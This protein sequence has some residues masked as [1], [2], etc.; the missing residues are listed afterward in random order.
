ME[1]VS[2]VAVGVTG[3]QGEEWRIAIDISGEDRR[4]VERDQRTIRLIRI[5]P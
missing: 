3:L 5:L 2:A 4:G 1:D